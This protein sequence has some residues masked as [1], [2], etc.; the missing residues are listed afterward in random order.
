MTGAIITG[1]A[2]AV[3][4]SDLS[5]VSLF[6]SAHI[7]VKIVMV[8]L[9]ASSVWGWAVIVDKT[10]TFKRSKMEADDFEKASGRDSISTS[11][12]RF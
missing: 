10:I 6:L 5:F 11:C 8:G 1:L 12:I 2:A 9:L 7:V 3:P 4:H